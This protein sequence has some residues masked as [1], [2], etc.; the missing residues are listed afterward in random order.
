MKILKES[1]FQLPI[2]FLDE[3]CE[4]E[5]HII[6]DLELK[7]NEN[8]KKSLYD[9]AFLPQENSFGEKTLGLWSQ[10]Y[11]ADKR[12]IEDS[13]KLLKMQAQQ[14]LDQKKETKEVLDIWK[15]I[16]EETGFIYKYQYIEYAKFEQFNNNPAFLQ[17]LSIFNMTSPVLSLLIPI[18]FLIIPLVLLRIQGVPLSTQTYFETL[19]MVFQKHHIGQLFTLNTASVD[20]A[21]YILISFAFYL[22]QI[23]QNI[24]ACIKF[25]RNMH[26]IHSQLF[27]IRD[28]LSKTLQ[29]IDLFEEQCADLKSYRPFI[30]DMKINAKVIEEMVEEYNEILPFTSLFSFKKIAQIGHVMKCFYQLY[31]R[32]E[33]HIALDYSFGL[34]G[35]LENLQGLSENIRMNKVGKWQ[36][37]EAEEVEQQVEGGDKK[38]NKKKNKRSRH[39]EQDKKADAKFTEAYF[40]ALMNANPVKNTYTLQKHMLI[41]GPNAAGKT[42]LLKTTIFNIIMTQQTGFGFYQ[43]AV[44]EPYDMIHCYINIP[45]TSGRD[46][47]FQAEARR[48]KEILDKISLAEEKKKRH[49]CVFDELYSGT[50]PYEA[51]GS[52]YAFL[53]Y[54]NK[55][56]NVNFVLTTHFLDLCK[57]FAENKAASDIKNYQ[58]RINTEDKDN[59]Q[60]TYEL[61]DGISAI[62]GGVKVLKD[63]QYPSEIIQVMQEVL[64][65]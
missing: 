4:L 5:N 55:Y 53:T 23:Y 13:Q 35:Y 29:K 18:F 49:F 10:Y 45:D 44:F 6:S 21:V 25:F 11:T 61:I 14:H 48:C 60:Y 31:N 32:E 40:P 8:T 17:C 57:R 36:A 9:Y 39:K 12:F 65:V 50:N 28:Y 34:N 2:S 62:K 42:T 26:K 19:K 37:E 63:L 1:A 64:S 7:V 3:K 56:K 47:L 15:E 43:S 46:S 41:T 24:M 54:L 30:K 52:A 51:V 20:R 27:T 59:F 33:Y 22:F 38:K 58:M 16:Q